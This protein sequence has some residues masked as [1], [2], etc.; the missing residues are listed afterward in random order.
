ME[1]LHFAAHTTDDG[2]DSDDTDTSDA[3]AADDQTE[4]RDVMFSLFWNLCSS[5]DHD[6]NTH[7]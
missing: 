1:T 3:D 7:Y 4:T 6:Y 2:Y 5:L